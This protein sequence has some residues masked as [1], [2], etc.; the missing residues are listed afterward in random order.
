MVFYKKIYQNL[1]NDKN[2][3]IINVKKWY[4]RKRGSEKDPKAKD[5]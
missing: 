2:L 1:N 3:S 5:L 4:E